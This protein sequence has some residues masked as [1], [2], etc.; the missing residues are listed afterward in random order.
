[1]NEIQKKISTAMKYLSALSVSG[2][3]VDVVAA[4]KVRLREAIELAKTTDTEADT[5]G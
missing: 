5:D 3:A 1:M 2:D 4:V